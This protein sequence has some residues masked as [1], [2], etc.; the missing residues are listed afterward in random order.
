MVRCR[1]VLLIVLMLLF[2]PGSPLAGEKKQNI[3]I[4]VFAAAS[5]SEA[6]HEIAKIYHNANPTVTVEFSFAGSQQLVQQLSEG[7]RA[8]VFASADTKQ[9][10][11]AVHSGRIDSSSVRTFAHNKLVIIAPNTGNSIESIRDL[12]KAGT[13]IILA[14]EA[15]PAGRYSLQMLDRISIDSTYGRKFKEMVLHNVVS[16]EESVRAVLAKVVLDEADAGIVYVSDITG[17]PARKLYAIDI[18]D[19]WNVIATYP[20]A[21][22]KDSRH[23]E[24]AERFVECV[25]SMEGQ[26]VLRRFGFIAGVE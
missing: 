22:V 26:S 25:L 7:A 17:E 14:D 16:Y 9:M 13:K 5:L 23:H 8:D 21:T 24:E 3:Q 18:P 4:T 1:V 11:I 2:R 10:G 6:F 12:G 20:I 15:V 19:P